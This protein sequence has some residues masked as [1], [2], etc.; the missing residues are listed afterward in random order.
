MPTKA[1][2]GNIGRKWER[3][4]AKGPKWETRLRRS[5]GERYSVSGFPTIKW[6]PKGT[7]RRRRRPINSA[8]AGP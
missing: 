6:F 2:S 8:A 1:A 4:G 7:R 3:V 5:L